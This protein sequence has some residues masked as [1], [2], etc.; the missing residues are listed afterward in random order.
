MKLPTVRRIFGLKRARGMTLVEALVALV[1][2]S[3]GLLG[4]AAMQMTALR[5]NLGA[6]LRSQATVMAYDIADRMRANRTAA[7]ANAYV[8][9]MGAAPGG[10]TL[11][12]IDLVAWKDALTATLPS[13]D[14]SVQRVGNL[15]RITI[16]WNEQNGGTQTFTTHTQ[17]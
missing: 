11:A 14:G 2:L 7:N 12:D 1:V 13:G 17:I 6:H 3:V 16:T 15:F 4:I 5:N 10:A 9:G 8:V